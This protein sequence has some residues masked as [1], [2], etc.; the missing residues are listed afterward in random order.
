MFLLLSVFYCPCC[1]VWLGW[2]VVSSIAEMGLEVQK[3]KE[4]ECSSSS[5]GEKTVWN[6]ASL[7]YWRWRERLFQ[8]RLY[9]M[10]C[11][12]Q[13]EA[14]RRKRQELG[15]WSKRKKKKRGKK[16]ERRNA[17]LVTKLGESTCG[18][19]DLPHFPTMTRIFSPNYQNLPT[20]TY[21]YR[22]HI[23]P[24][25]KNISLINSILNVKTIVPFLLTTCWSM[26]LL[27]LIVPASSCVG[28]G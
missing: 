19:Q 25:R 28:R 20:T 2:A 6:L 8:R 21:H 1:C 15:I 17:L 3:G 5:L 18:N 7:V 24:S 22:R 9:K 4:A 27:T 14:I 16:N 26:L 23:S 12:A 11:S 10:G 13:R